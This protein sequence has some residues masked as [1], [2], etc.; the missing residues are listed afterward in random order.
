MP[1]VIVLGSWL[2]LGV[3]FALVAAVM[4]IHGLQQVVTGRPG[5]L[6]LPGARKRRPASELDF[7]RQ[8]AAQVLQA[9]SIVLIGGPAVLIGTNATLQLTGASPIERFQP[10]EVVLLFAYVGSIL[11]SVLCQLAALIVHSK[12]NYVSVGSGVA[13]AAN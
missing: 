4:V 13:R 6:P 7:V 12:V 9:I 2:A 8:G 11:F 1:E 5:F 10:I 3:L